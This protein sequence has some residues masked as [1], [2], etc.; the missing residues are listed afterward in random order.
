MRRAIAGL[1]A[2]LLA[3]AA[4]ASV[5]RP[6]VLLVVIDDVGFTDLGAYGG[7]AAT[8]VLDALAKRG[9]KLVKMP[10]PYGDAQWRLYDISVDPGETH[11]LSTER[12][13][14]AAELREAYAAFAMQVGVV[15]MSP[16]YEPVRQAWKYN[17]QTMLEKRAP[18]F[19]AG[20]AVLI[21]VVI[22]ART[23][24]RQRAAP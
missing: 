5:A 1:T 10:R 15:E 16:E 18:T 14:L 17:L 21:V 23:W 3:P 19:F 12:P 6:N 7:D 2:V 11:D 24:R 8:P 22:A 13:E 9:T 4:S 20:A